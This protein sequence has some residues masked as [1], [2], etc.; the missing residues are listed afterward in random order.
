MVENKILDLTRFMSHIPT[1][2]ALEDS[3]IIIISH[4]SR[5]GKSDFT[6]LEPHA[7]K[8]GELLGKDVRYIDD[9]F[10]SRA[11][12]AIKNSDPGDII[13]LENIRFYSEETLN[14]N[15]EKHAETHLV[16]KLS[17]VTEF[18]VNDAFS[19]SHRPHAS[20]I[21]FPPV[22]PS[23]IGLLMKKELSAISRVMKGDGEKLFILGG[24]KIDDSIMVMKNVLERKIADRVILTG[25]VAN[26]CMMVRGDKIGR[27]NEKIVRDSVTGTDD[28]DTERFL[29]KFGRKIVFPE[30]VAVLRRGERKEVSLKELRDDDVIYDIGVESI[31][32][33]VDEIKSHDIS[34]MNGPAGVF[35]DER[36][37][38]GT[39]EL[40]R[41]MTQTS[42]SFIGGGHIS[43]AAKMAGVDGKLD[44]VSTGGGASILL[45][46]GEP[47]IGIETIKTYWNKKWK[48]LFSRQ[49]T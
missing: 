48:K 39:F 33:F 25:L 17:K 7:K 30:D 24:A 28:S 14:Q 36:F 21:G 35:E 3:T 11:I 20:I 23:Y 46:S 29:K 27:K 34:V 49:K 4:Q 41:A 43:T 44:H 37:A 31:A 10:G 40:L 26:Y 5:P 13:L 18:Y 9:I 19:A 32:K 47:L 45:L 38:L 12:D 42:F 8:L 15:P 2:K 16:R 1:L 6:T 22:L